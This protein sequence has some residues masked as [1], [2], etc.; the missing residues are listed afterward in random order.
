VSNANGLISYIIGQGVVGT[1]VF[2]DINW[3]KGPYYLKTEA[4]PT[5]G[6]SYTITGT[7]QLLSLPYAFYANNGY[8]NDSSLHY[9]VFMGQ[10]SG[11]YNTTGNRN[12]SSGFGTLNYNTT[13]HNNTA[14]GFISLSNN[15]T[16]YYNTATGAQ[17][18][19]LNTSGHHNTATG[20]MSLVSDTTGNYNTANG[21]YSM[22][23]NT[24]GDQ[25]TATGFESLYHNTTGIY[26]SAN[27][28]R[29]LISN[30]TGTC[31]TANGF[32]ALYHNKTGS[33][34]VAN[35]SQALYYDSIGSNN[36]AIGHN[37]GYNNYGTGNV[38]IGKDAGANEAGSNKLYISNSNTATP[39]V[40]GEF[41]YK[42]V[43][44]NDVLKLTP[45]AAAPSSPVNGMLYVNSTTNKLYC[46][47]NGA[48]KS[49]S[50]TGSNTGDMLY[51]KDTAWVKIPV[52]LPGQRLQ[53]TASN[54]PAWTGAQYPTLTTDGVSD[55]GNTHAISGG[56]ITSDGGSAVTARGVCWSRLQ[57]P[58]IPVSGHGDS[59]TID[60][61]GII[62]YYSFITGLSL[63][64]TYYVRAYA[65]N[66]AGTGYG[67][68]V[69]FTTELAIGDTCQGG[70]IAYIL[71]P[72]DPGYI[73]G[74]IHGLIAS[75]TP[76]FFTNMLHWTNNGVYTTTGATATA[77]GTGNAN[78]NTIID[79][80]GIGGYA[81]YDVTHNYPNGYSDWYLPSK[82]ELY[83]ISMNVGAI[84]GFY[85]IAYY[86]SS[87]EYDNS[88]AWCLS[89]SEDD[90]HFV[91][92]LKTHPHH[93][94][95][96]RSF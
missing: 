58:T 83:L 30:T 90:V 38:F 93:S 27:G 69:S 54:L 1:G 25:N 15:K 8:Y 81:A 35:G 19:Y 18:L 91:C 66:S 31:N 87:S 74:E 86:W 77:F 34:N 32:D 63:G 3:G 73:P 51:W 60:G 61:S 71:Q 13:G 48:W 20:F 78:T 45:R 95:P 6:T 43:T 85:D 84:P 2:A 23:S 10:G 11:S 47:L 39:L 57:N 59:L 40:Y 24:T 67:N 46:Y 70:N 37:A 96:I 68:E 65:T 36:V 55:I 22:V 4:D 53:L 44:I 17:S 12:Q 94:C 49:A 88:H 56:N 80:L 33:Y 41:D 42:T 75:L 14:N 50:I 16:G 92:E 89:V 82:D 52:G 29:A 79:S 26:N 7:T 9:N 21:A 72:G 76:H 62:E 64:I 5:G 28:S